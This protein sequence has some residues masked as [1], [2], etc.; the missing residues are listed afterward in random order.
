M[1]AFHAVYLNIAIYVWFA[2]FAQFNDNRTIDKRARVDTLVISVPM[3]SA[4]FRRSNFLYSADKFDL[5]FNAVALSIGS[6][7]RRCD[8]A[9]YFT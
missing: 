9:F 4:L 2:N 5:Q 7:C 1:W 8:D 6:I 3:Q